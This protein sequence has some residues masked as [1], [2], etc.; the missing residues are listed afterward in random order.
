MNIRQLLEQD[1]RPFASYPRVD[2][3]FPAAAIED[4][5]T[6]LNRSIQRGDGPG[7]VIGSAGTGKS[8]LLQALAAQY[9]DRFDVVLLACSQICTRRALLQ[10]I[11]F[12][13]G[14]PHRQRDEG[15]VRLALLD[16]LLSDE[17]GPEGLLLLVDEAQS[18]S[19]ALLEELRMMTNLVRGGMPRVRLVLAGAPALEEAF[20]APELESFSQRLAARCYLSPFGRDET[21]QY[22]RAQLAASGAEPDVVFAPDA[23]D[24]VVE[25]TDGV[26][27]LVNQLCDRALLAAGDKDCPHVDRQIVRAAWADLQQLPTPW[28]T[29]AASAP[30]KGGTLEFGSLTSGA[31]DARPATISVEG[32]SVADEDSS[33]RGIGVGDA[34]HSIDALPA[35]LD[36]PVEDAEDMPS[37][38]TVGT[39]R[40]VGPL[41]VSA[42]RQV[43]PSAEPGITSSSEHPRVYAAEPEAAAD[44]FEEQFDEEE[45]VLDNFASWDAV[46]REHVPHVENLRDPQFAARVQEA[47]DTALPLPEGEGLEAAAGS[48]DE[49]AEPADDNWPPLRLAV[50][51]ET[52]TLQPIPLIRST[53]PAVVTAAA[54]FDPVM[55]EAAGPSFCAEATHDA[56]YAVGVASVVDGGWEPTPRGVGVGLRRTQ[57]SGDASHAGRPDAVEAPVLVIEDDRDEAEQTR[58]AVR[59]QEYRRLFSRLRGM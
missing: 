47:M 10:A 12:E 24:A 53:G 45:I 1:H 28:D 55:P 21:I 39:D 30:D 35:D 41:A 13:L 48:E 40:P 9:H 50:V 16:Q 58:P 22:I 57:A 54:A 34:S 31:A 2:R 6:R 23:W 27:R 36:V 15:E 14:L 8:L 18:L 59:R 37:E 52:A 5:R 33:V 3:Y 25:A 20:A 4:A 32:D 19:I 38:V 11:L 29:P 43:G 46:W 42:D 44:P 49:P 17:Q 56:D 7:L 26:P 51:S